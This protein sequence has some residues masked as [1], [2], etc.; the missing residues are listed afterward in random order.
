MG[1]WN[2]WISPDDYCKQSML[3]LNFKPWRRRTLHSWC[4]VQPRKHNRTRPQCQWSQRLE[5]IWENL[6]KRWTKSRKPTW[7]ARPAHRIFPCMGRCPYSPSLKKTRMRQSC[8]NLGF[9]KP[10]KRLVNVP[11][12][13]QLLLRPA[14]AGSW[15]LACCQYSNSKVFSLVHL[16]TLQRFINLHKISLSDNILWFDWW[17]FSVNWSVGL[18]LVVF[19]LIPLLHRHS[20]LPQVGW[21]TRWG[22]CQACPC[23]AAQTPQCPW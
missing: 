10:L 11:Y 17:W 5:P 13:Q 8:V 16:I 7:T 21:R 3:C 15:P 22:W 2:I 23:L 1:L 18:A 19:S 20:P 12:L 4:R 6:I 9:R 14:S